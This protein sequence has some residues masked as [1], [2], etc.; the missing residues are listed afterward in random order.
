[1]TTGDV[2]KFG[3]LQKDTKT[4]FEDINLYTVPSNLAA[5]LKILLGILA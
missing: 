5:I 1:V 4:I 3:I 2:W